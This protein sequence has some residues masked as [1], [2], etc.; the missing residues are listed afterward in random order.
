MKKRTLPKINS[1]HFALPWLGAGLLLGVI[2]P[3]LIHLVT[4]YFCVPLCIL[5]GVIWLS[6][7]V[8]FAIE[9]HQDFGR[10]PYFQKHLAQEIPFDREKQYAVMRCSICT[11]E[12]V[13]GF[14]SREDHSLVEV[15]VIRS[16]KDLQYFRKVYGIDEIIREY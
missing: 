1:V 5:G 3:G 15:M 14:R 9:M 11:G 2:L 4:G 6:F 10:T 13:V 8:V 7:G 12:R 16:E